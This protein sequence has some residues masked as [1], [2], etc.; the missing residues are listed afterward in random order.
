MT[1]G[2]PA[3][4]TILAAC[5]LEAMPPTA[6]ALSVPRACFS[7][8]ASRCSTTLMVLGLALPKFSMK[9]STV[10][11]ITSASAGSRQATRAES[12]S[13]SP[14]FNSVNEM[15][16][17]SLMIGDDAVAEERD[18]SGAGVEVAL[19]MLQVVVGEEHLGDAQ[20][21]VAEELS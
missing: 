11:K 9:P 7:M 5:S 14:N 2:M 19:V 15:A 21:G 4:M 17:F 16:S 3:R 6:V 13:L 18:Q 12:W 10:V 1:R 20:A 8:A